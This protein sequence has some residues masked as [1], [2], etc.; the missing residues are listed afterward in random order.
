MRQIVQ[1]SYIKGF[2]FHSLTEASTFINTQKISKSVLVNDTY[3]DNYYCYVCYHALS[4]EKLFAL[5]FGSDE[6]ESNF[7]FL[8]WDDLLVFDTGKDLY[9]IDQSLSVVQVLEITTPLIGLYQIGI[10]RLLL[11]E[12]GYLRIINRRGEILNDRLFDLIEDFSIKDNLLF[13]HTNE[14]NSVINLSE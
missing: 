3:G 2:R 11:L 13:I 12:E 7:N 5:Y 1:N 6:D 10:E 14:G 4:R 9:I 8:F